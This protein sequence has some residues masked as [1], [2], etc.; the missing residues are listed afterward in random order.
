MGKLS[1][2]KVAALKEPGRYSDG[3]NL[4]LQVGP[5]GNKS[6]A[7]LFMRDG[8]ARQMGLAK[9]ASRAIGLPGYRRR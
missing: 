3:D 1:V 9:A 6:W 4:F 2:F 5:K 8:R 7:F